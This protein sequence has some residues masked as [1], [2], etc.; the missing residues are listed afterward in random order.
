VR[1]IDGN[2]E[3]AMEF[4]DLGSLGD[5]LRVR[6]PLPEDALGAILAQT[7]AALHHLHKEMHAVHRDLKPQNLLLS[8]SGQAKLSDFGCVAELQDSFGKCGTFVGTVPYM[9]PERIHGGQ[10]SYASDIWSLGLTTVEAA[11]GHFPYARFNGYWG[12][13]HAVLNEPSPELPRARFSSEICDFVAHCLRKEAAQRPSARV[14]L[15][16]P[17]IARA[18]A[19][20]FSLKDFL[21]SEAA[22]A[23]TTASGG[24][25][26]GGGDGG[27]GS[28]SSSGGESRSGS[29]TGG[30]RG[31]SHSPARLAHSSV[32]PA[33]PQFVPRRC[34]RSDEGGGARGGEGGGDGALGAAIGGALDAGGRP[35]AL[36]EVFSDSEAEE[37]VEDISLDLT[38]DGIS[39]VLGPLS[40]HLGPPSDPSAGE[41]S[42]LSPFS[43]MRTLPTSRFTDREGE[44]PSTGERHRGAITPP[45]SSMR[46][47]SDSAPRR[48]FP[49]ATTAMRSPAAE[50][51][52]IAAARALRAANTGLQDSLAALSRELDASLAQLGASRSEAQSLR[53][54]LQASQYSDT[55]LRQQCDE[56]EGLVSSLKAQIEALELQAEIRAEG[57]GQRAPTRRGDA[58]SLM[59]VAADAAPASST[60]HIA[61]P[62]SGAARRIAPG[63]PHGSAYPAGDGAAM[64]V[65]LDGR[66]LTGLHPADLERLCALTER[67]LHEIR[68]AMRRPNGR[69]RAPS[70]AG[71][72]EG[73]HA[74]RGFGAAASSDLAPAPA[75]AASEEE[76]SVVGGRAPRTLRPTSSTP[77]QKEAPALTPKSRRGE[78]ARTP[79][80]QRA[81][82]LRLGLALGGPKTPTSSSARG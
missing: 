78:A 15:Q 1:Y 64:P 61:R 23:A 73:R 4:M 40:D 75:A 27:S 51:G 67:N 24:G 82:S 45:S 14:L 41:K 47:L 10:Y 12:I 80:V 81:V 52:A 74:E 71:G 69:T 11:L 7:L 39:D 72:A 5:R 48:A 58:A 43:E 62:P 28:G 63:E 57:E 26:A 60:A 46:S 8:S 38:S 77:A 76:L 70:A 30:R 79:T 50:G 13:L 53:Q 19:S 49:L 31:A 34:Q 6:G 29:V 25:G 36:G 3:I 65:S 54:E 9:S 33:P 55:L 22:A 37:V 2:I 42:S 35:A 20:S 68:A 17:F 18:R 16:H 21:C 44:P 32:A 59:L 56:A 66:V